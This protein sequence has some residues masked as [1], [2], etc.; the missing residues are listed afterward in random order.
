MMQSFYDAAPFPADSLHDSLE[1]LVGQLPS[2]EQP[3]S[4]SII[5][6]VGGQ[7]IWT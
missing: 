6:T 7:E 3:T 5:L 1:L 4:T 2:V